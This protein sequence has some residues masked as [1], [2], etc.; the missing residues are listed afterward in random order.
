MKQ[1]TKAIFSIIS[2]GVEKYK[3]RGGAI[4]GNY[5]FLKKKNNASNVITV[6]LTRVHEEANDVST[7]TQRT[8][9]S[10]PRIASDM[11]K[12][13]LLAYSTIAKQGV[14]GTRAPV[15]ETLAKGIPYLHLERGQRRLL[16]V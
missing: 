3:Q 11:P 7:G 12:I 16:H 5:E 1:L 6:V 8:A 9:L 14:T 15:H 13:T 10:R 4:R 2:E